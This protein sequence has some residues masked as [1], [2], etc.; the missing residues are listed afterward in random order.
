LFEI[1][2][3]TQEKGQNA[4]EVRKDGSAKLGGARENEPNAVVTADF[5]MKHIHPIGSIWI[6]GKDNS[7]E[8]IHPAT[9]FGGTWELIDQNFANNH[10]AYNSNTDVD[11]FSGVIEDGEISVSAVLS[12]KTLRLRIGVKSGRIYSDTNF[13]IGK[14]NLE[15]L[16]VTNLTYT[17]N[18]ILS[19]TDY[20]TGDNKGVVM[21]NLGH[22]GTLTHTEVVLGEGSK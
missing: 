12:G 14:I 4:F 9:L 21:T 10:L 5:M 8:K 18:Y 17:Y 6:G 2:N 15:K 13:T 16:G 22:D 3:G 11:A 20:T 19:S 7:G 1:G